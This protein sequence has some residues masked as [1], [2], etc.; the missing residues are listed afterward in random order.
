MCLYL[1]DNNPDGIVPQ[2]T[3]SVPA[4]ACLPPSIS[5]CMH[6][7]SPTKKFFTS[8]QL[9]QPSTTLMCNDVQT[10]Q[11]TVVYNSLQLPSKCS[12]NK[13][14]SQCIITFPDITTENIHCSPD[15]LSSGPAES[16][17]ISWILY[18]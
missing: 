15:A 11:I 7:I 10:K 2:R 17:N 1:N 8:L 4:N 6:T 14:K 16:Q 9:I 5:M 12:Q 18:I 13:I 3:N